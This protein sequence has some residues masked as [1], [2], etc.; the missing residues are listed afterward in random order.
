MK[1]THLT[2]FTLALLAAPFYRPLNAQTLG[3][4]SEDF[5][6]VLRPDTTELP[7]EIQDD[8][9]SRASMDSSTDPTGK[10]LYLFGPTHV[11]TD[12]SSRTGIA[13]GMVIKTV[14]QSSTGGKEPGLSVTALGQ[15]SNLGTED[16]SLST[17]VSVGLVK[18]ARPFRRSEAGTLGLALVYADVK[19]VSS[20]ER[21][22]V[23]WEKK[24]GQQE[25]SL[26]LNA[27]WA[28]QTAEDGSAVDD[29]QFG[30]GLLFNP[31]SL[32]GMS[33]GVDYSLEDDIAGEDSYALTFTHTLLISSTLSKIK[34]GVGKHGTLNLGYTVIFGAT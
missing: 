8:L 22:Q 27:G 1:K 21:V 5:G 14:R 31:P 34:F 29:A 2:V 18:L 12:T 24:L 20:T 13:A 16:G 28:E 19:D 25:T 6:L 9:E 26:T 11:D 23:L 30:V 33:I 17:D 10:T 15:Y 32:Q 3:L 4:S 7:V